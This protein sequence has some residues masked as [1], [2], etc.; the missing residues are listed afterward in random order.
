M[1]NRSRGNS[2]IIVISEILSAPEYKPHTLNLK[3][4]KKFY[5]YKPQVSTL[6]ASLFKSQVSKRMKKV[7]AYSTQIM[8]I[9]VVAPRWRQPSNVNVYVYS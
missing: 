6:A 7:A 8:V 3:R 1:A 5:I 4:K 9:I 2:Q